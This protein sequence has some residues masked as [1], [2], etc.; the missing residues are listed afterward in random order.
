MDQGAKDYWPNDANTRTHIMDI[1]L[2]L[3]NSIYHNQRVL[4]ALIMS[5]IMMKAWW[6]SGVGTKNE[7]EQFCVDIMIF[8][9]NIYLCLISLGSFFIDTFTMDLRWCGYS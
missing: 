4:M 1:N 3:F 5:N 6:I 2:E 8:V 9:L 7:T